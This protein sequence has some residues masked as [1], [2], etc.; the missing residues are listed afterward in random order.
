VASI[1]AFFSNFDPRTVAVMI[2]SKDGIDPIRYRRYLE[3]C[4]A[5]HLS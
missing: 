1:E 4:W 5:K 3:L 2:H